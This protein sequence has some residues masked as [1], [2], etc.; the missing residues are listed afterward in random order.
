MRYYPSNSSVIYRLPQTRLTVFVA[1]LGLMGTLSTGF[2]LAADPSL[3]WYSYKA[4][5]G[6]N[7]RGQSVVRADA[8]GKIKI[9]Y[10]AG[11]NVR[12][13]ELDKNQFTP[14]VV[15]DTAI[16][17]DA[18]MDMALD[19]DGAPFILHQDWRYQ[20][21][22][23]AFKTDSKWGNVLVA[24]NRADNLD[25]YSLCL[26]VNDAG[27]VHMAYPLDES[28]TAFLNYSKRDKEG[29]LTDPE[30]LDKS[31]RNGKW[32][33]MT[34][35]KDGYPIIANYLFGTTS[36]ALYK[37]GD[38]KWD[39]SAIDTVSSSGEHGFHSTLVRGA[40]DKYRIAYVHKDRKALL[41]A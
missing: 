34:L 28:G 6:D 1:L 7:L 14:S 16:G 21:V 13:S 27:D 33:S 39:S 22:Y 35:D 36:V 25:Y 4:D 40:D 41:F 12:Y 9:A 24:N 29:K 11:Q 3:Y 37:K 31:T 15:A 8:K 32:N 5:S 23:L 10:L 30:K 26:Q 20:R 19:K 2:A 18:R 38:S 17:G